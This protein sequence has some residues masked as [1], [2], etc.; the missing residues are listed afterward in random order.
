MAN[1]KVHES[2]QKQKKYFGYL[3]LFLFLGSSVA[4]GL[5]YG[6]ARISL[7]NDPRLDK[8][9]DDTQIQ[10]LVQN[11]GAYIVA[12]VSPSDEQALADIVLRYRPLVYLYAETVSQTTIIQVT[13]ASGTKSFPALDSEQLEIHLC[14]NV[15]PALP[16]CQTQRA[17]RSFENGTQ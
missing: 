11:Q 1:K 3:V 14:D 12:K 5:L 13:T 10:L 7:P 4:I 8:Q 6:S 17:M 15:N 9:L 16:E 2:R